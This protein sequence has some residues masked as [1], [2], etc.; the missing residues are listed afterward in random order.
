MSDEPNTDDVCPCCDGDM[1]QP[2]GCDECGG[3]GIANPAVRAQMAADFR[4][5]EAP[6]CTEAAPCFACLRCSI[7]LLNLIPEAARKADAA[8]E[9]ADGG[10]Q[11]TPSPEKPDHYTFGPLSAERTITLTANFVATLPTG[12][13]VELPAGTV[14]RE[15]T[16]AVDHKHLL[17][18]AR[19]VVDHDVAQALTGPVAH[20]LLSALRAACGDSIEDVA[21]RAGPPEPMSPAWI[22][23]QFR[24]VTQAEG[25]AI[26]ADLTERVGLPREMAPSE[27]PT[28]RAMAEAACHKRSLGQGFQSG[29]EE[30]VIA[31]RARFEAAPLVSLADY[32]KPRT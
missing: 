15:G 18:C 9:A 32:A 24:E 28:P 13:R 22:N 25:E 31:E 4:A 2:D 3:S 7:R 27:W 5:P 14:L 17:A 26:L 23:A 21:L 11:W 29:F 1:S 6:A 16:G 20:A 10:G 19:G 12:E 30:G 8:I